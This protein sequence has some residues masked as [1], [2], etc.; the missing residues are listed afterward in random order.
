[1]MLQ[2]RERPV[3]QLKLFDIVKLKSDVSEAG[4]PPWG[5]SVAAGALG[6]IVEELRNSFYLVEFGEEDSE[7][8]ILTLPSDMLILEWSAPK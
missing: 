4:S 7:P 6:A 8:T 2:K 1:M 3:E 5:G